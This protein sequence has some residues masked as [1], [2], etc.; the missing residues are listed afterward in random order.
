MN[1]LLE[2]VVFVI[3]AIIQRVVF[4]RF[5]VISKDVRHHHQRRVCTGVENVTGSLE[6]VTFANLIV[7][8]CNPFTTPP[9]AFVEIQV[10]LTMVTGKVVWQA[11]RCPAEKN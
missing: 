1:K 11:V 5:E 10:Q 7:L 2:V 9:D 3:Q 4:V 6:P 8:D